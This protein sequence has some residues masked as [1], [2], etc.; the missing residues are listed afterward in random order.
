M[1]SLRYQPSPRSRLDFPALKW[2]PFRPC[3]NDFHIDQNLAKRYSSQSATEAIRSSTRP[4]VQ[5]GHSCI[6]CKSL[7]RTSA[8]T[9][10]RCA[11]YG[12]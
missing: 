5:I 11:I 10:N 9:P 8:A 3:P 2:M 1:N 6:V 7:H 4:H 12:T